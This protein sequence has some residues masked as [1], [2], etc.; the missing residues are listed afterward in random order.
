[1]SRAPLALIAAALTGVQVGAALVATR[2]LVADVGPMLLAFLR[3][4]IGVLIVVPAV[5]SIEWTRYRRTD[6]L[7]IVLLGVGQFGVLIALLNLAILFIDA[8]EAALVFATFP[9]LT[10]ALSV[11][12]K[13]EPY[14]HWRALGITITIVGVAFSLGLESVRTDVSADRLLGLA[15]AFL[16]AFAGAVCAVFYR[17]YLERYPTVQVSVTAMASA[18]LV[19]APFA[20]IEGGLAVMPGLSA[21]AWLVIVFVGVSSGLGYI[22]WLF[23]LR[24][25]PPSTV[26]IFLGLG[27]P[28]A[29]GLAY[30]FLAEPVAPGDVLG[31]IIVGLGLVIAFPVAHRLR[32]A[33]RRAEPN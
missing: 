10:L 33:G 9:L 1:M 22:L 27:P 6:V 28:A 20:L 13:R 29:A 5:L 21:M 23:A 3:Y 16:S 19:L 25:A 4:A 12:L 15:L 7:P 24:Y 32:M 2:Y 31:S 18:T 11:A 8:A 26:T 14:S 30:L 17:P